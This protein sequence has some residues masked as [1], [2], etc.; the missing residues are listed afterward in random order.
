MFRTVGNIMLYVS[1]CFL[2]LIAAGSS[3][4]SAYLGPLE[5]LSRIIAN[6]PNYGIIGGRTAKITDYP[7]MV[8]FNREG[9]FVGGG[10]ILTDRW[11]ISSGYLFIHARPN[12]VFARAGSIYPSYGGQILNI[13]KI[14]FHEKFDLSYKYNIALLKT[15]QTIKFSWTVQ[16]IKIAVSVPRPGMIATISGFGS[17]S[18]NVTHNF[19]GINLLA[20]PAQIKTQDMCK[21]QYRNLPDTCFCAHSAGAAPC[22]GDIGDPLVYNK[23]LIGFYVGGDICNYFNR[24][25]VYTN[26]T[27][28]RSWVIQK[29][30]QNSESDEMSAI[31]DYLYDA[32]VNADDWF[33]TTKEILLRKGYYT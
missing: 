24:S 9:Y 3:F 12:S 18:I 22:L 5:H 29:I 4:P 2:G 20:A 33:D 1:V 19:T 27:T 10:A 13:S 28:L 32:Y 23:H 15:T 7:Y 26:V 17:T 30:K 25:E 11:I 14:I 31:Y 21:K 16:P 6:K 8:S